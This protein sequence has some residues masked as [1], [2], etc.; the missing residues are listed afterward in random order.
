[1]S[2]RA[3]GMAIDSIPGPD[4]RGV[5]GVRPPILVEKQYNYDKTLVLSFD[6]CVTSPLSM[7]A[8]SSPVF[9][10]NITNF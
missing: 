4:L 6:L 7:S 5:R 2:Y 8:G 1:M 3:V 9:H 10:S